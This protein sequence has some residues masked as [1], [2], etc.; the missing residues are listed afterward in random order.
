MRSGPCPPEGLPLP[1]INAVVPSVVESVNRTT[2]HSGENVRKQF[3]IG[4]LCAFTAIAATAQ[5]TPKPAPA[6]TADPV[7]IKYGNGEIRKSEF[8]AAIATLPAEYQGYVA[9]A[10][11]RAFAEDYLRMKMLAAEAE[12][13]GLD[14]DAEVQAQLQLM[15]ANALA[16]AQLARLE[17]G[18]T[19]S[20]AEVQAAYDAR[21]S[22][23]EQA[24]ARHILIAFKGSPAAQPGKPELTEEQAKA[25]A[26]ELR[27]K[28]V[29][30]AD[31]AEIAKNES[32]DLGSGSRGGDLGSFGK[33]QMVPE[34]DKAVFENKVGEVGPVVR[35]QFGYHIVQV[36][37]RGA[38]PMTE[39]RPSIEKELKDKK[40]QDM[41]EGMKVAA[42]ATFDD[43]YFATPPA[44]TPAASN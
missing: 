29:A 40:L 23:L 22:E 37:E 34:F 17:A 42:K 38:A 27:A 5:N 32:D 9:G 15:R 13:N 1:G 24:K 35:T 36:Q 3:A 2:H 10:G 28:I 25:K 26:D 21:K 12:K 18:I 19:V 4:L 8:E 30:G 14:K 31:F 20:D 33:G 11:K 16:T 44:A 39:V 43:A 41:L 7:I 6:D